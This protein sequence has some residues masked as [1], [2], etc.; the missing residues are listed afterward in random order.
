MGKGVYHDSAHT[1]QSTCTVVGLA[2][3]QTMQQMDRGCTRTSWRAR[4]HAS[5]PYANIGRAAPEVTQAVKTATERISSMIMIMILL[6]YRYK[7]AF[8]RTRRALHS[9]SETSA[10]PPFVFPLQL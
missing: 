7:A 9:G 4:V 6:D 3:W 10:P 8:A 1:S 5:K 2:G